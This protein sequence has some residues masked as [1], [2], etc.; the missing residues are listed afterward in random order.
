VLSDPD[1]ILFDPPARLSFGALWRNFIEA[2]PR[3]TYEQGLTRIRGPFKDT[4]LICDPDLIH[5][6]LVEKTSEVG[7]STLASRIFAY[8]LGDSSIFMSEGA[9]WHWKHRALASMFRY[10]AL[11]GSVPVF[12]GMA[13]RQV[14][15]WANRSSQGPVNVAL[16]MREVM[17]DI[18]VHSML[19]VSAKLDVEA[20]GAAI[21]DAFEMVPWQTFL[22]VLSAPRWLPFPG[23]RRLIRARKYVFTQVAHIVAARRAAPTLDSDLLNVLIAARDSDGRAMSDEEIT[24]DLITFV[25]TGHEVGTRALAW[26]LWLLAK[27]QPT[28]QRMWEEVRAVAGEQPIEPAHVEQLTFTEQVVQESM[29][30]FPAA[31]ILLRQARVD[32]MLGSH[33]VKAGTHIHIPIYSL[34][35]N[36]RLWDNPNAFDP[37]R[38]ARNRIKHPRYAYL[39]FGAGPR[40]C[41]GASFTMIEIVVILATMVRAFR[42]RPVPGHKP[43]PRARISLRVKDGMP[44]FIEPRTRAG[45][46]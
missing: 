19:G 25:S 10:E 45:A 41:I 12:A 17:F 11:L 38:F 23:R 32:M 31:L 42:F 9:N 30:L 43:K 39:P 26:T 1:L 37:D 16:A 5:E 22:D 46:D 2:F 14:E 44:L 34:H 6:V 20:Y 3:S 7:R 35:R 13:E 15:R 29:R 27:D 21:T 4:L 24:N 36:V 40:V 18:I 28:Q 8:F 33:P